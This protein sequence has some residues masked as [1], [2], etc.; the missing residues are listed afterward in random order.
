MRK[1]GI[2]LAVIGV[3]LVALAAVLRF[4]IVPGQEQLPSDTNKTRHYSGT[5][6]VTMNPAALT[7]GNLAALFVRNVP[8]SIDRTVKVTATDGQSAIVTD[9]RTVRTTTGTQLS[10]FDYTY[11]VDRKTLEPVPAFGGAQVTPA[12]GLTVSWPF[13]TEQK[14]YTAYVQ[15]TQGTTPAKYSGEATKNGLN[16]YVFKTDVAPSKITEPKVLANLPATLSKST[17]A[18]LP[19]A[20]GYTDAQAKALAQLL[21]TM[22]DPVPITYLYSAQTTLWVAPTTGSI[23][24]TQKSET[25]Q[26]VL[27]VPGMAQPVP[28]AT[29]QA[30]TYQQTAASVG[31]AVTDAK[32]ADNKITLYGTTLPLVAL[33]GGVVLVVVGV[34]MWR[35]P[36]SEPPMPTH[37][38]ITPTTTP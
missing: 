7:S 30:L 12:K 9:S 23:V 34:L 2:V 25:R 15:D 3:L 17:L 5:L 26:A 14:D 19:K 1:T 10:A 22:P 31:E 18:A 35:R 28:L 38:D 21:V 24:D 29:V 33:I 37:E 11:A 36:E 4:V 20:L 8:V 27:S 32:D 6:S 13:G 16:T